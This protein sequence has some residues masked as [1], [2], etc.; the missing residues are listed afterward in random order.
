MKNLIDA[1]TEFR[2]FFIFLSKDRWFKTI[3]NPRDLDKVNKTCNKNGTSKWAYELTNFVFK[4]ISLERHVRPLKVAS[5]RK[6]GGTA[7]LMLSVQCDCS[8]S[9]SHGSTIIDPV[10]ELNSK[11]VV[12]FEYKDETKPEGIRVL[13]SSWHLDKHDSKKKTSSSHPLYHYEFGGSE[14]TKTEGFDFGDLI[15]IDSPRIMHPPMDLVLS[16]DFVIKNYYDY[17]VHKSLTEQEAYKNYIKNAKYR[18]WRP[19]ALMLASHFHDFSSVYTIDPVYAKNIV[20]CEN[21]SGK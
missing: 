18:L 2:N 8:I 20:H 13:Q 6:T 15:L 7:K 11:I 5:L 19:Y 14:L 16:I 21:I 17:K 12:Q 9:N 1:Q 4:N 3:C 10:K